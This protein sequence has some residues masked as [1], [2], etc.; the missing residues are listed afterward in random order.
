MIDFAFLRSEPDAVRA[1]QVARGESSS[2]VDDVLAADTVRRTAIANFEGL[3]A[4]QKSLGGQVAKATGAEK[5]DLLA[6]T[7]TLSDQVKVA[8]A[9][10][11]K[12]EAAASPASNDVLKH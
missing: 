6:R 1:S 5:D 3:R 11:A 12:P 2:L 10:A 9:A 8:E 7:K 4:E